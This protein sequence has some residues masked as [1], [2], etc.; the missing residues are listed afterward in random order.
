[1]VGLN[2]HGFT[3]RKPVQHL[4]GHIADVRG[5]AYAVRDALILPL[6]TVA[7]T[8]CAVVRGN[9]RGDANVAKL[10]CKKRGMTHKIFLYVGRGMHGEFFGTA[11]RGVDGNITNAHGI[12]QSRNMVTVLMGDKDGIKLIGAFSHIGEG[13]FQRPRALSCVDKQLDGAAFQV[14]GVA[15]RA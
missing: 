11:A 15:P 10:Q 4:V 12:F 6:N 7:H 5:V 14:G 13:F 2:D 8:S 3:A 1:M 9:K